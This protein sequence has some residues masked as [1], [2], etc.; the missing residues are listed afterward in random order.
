MPREIAP[1]CRVPAWSATRFPESA[2]GHLGA[3]IT[4]VAE[5]PELL[6]Q[7]DMFL[8]CIMTRRYTRPSP[9]GKLDLP[10]KLR[11]LLGCARVFPPHMP[12]AFHIVWMTDPSFQDMASSSSSRVR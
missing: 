2:F 6:I 5:G 4:S 11:I 10:G 8:L 7:D 1:W 3:R 9:A 12:L